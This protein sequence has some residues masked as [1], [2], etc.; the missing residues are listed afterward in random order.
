MDNF[1][2]GVRLFCDLFV[3]ETYAV[4]TVQNNRKYL[5][6]DDILSK[7][8]IKQMNRGD[9][10]FRR[11]LNLLCVVWKDTRDVT[12]LSTMHP[13][14]G[15]QTVQR[16]T[17][18]N[19]AHVVLQVPVPPAVLDYNRFMGG[20]DKGDQFC[21]YYTVKR[22]TRKWWKVIFFRSVDISIVNAWILHRQSPLHEP[23][24][25]LEFR[26][27]LAEELIGDF[28]SRKQPGRPSLEQRLVGKHFLEKGVSQKC[29]V[30]VRTYKSKK[31]R[32]PRDS[33]YWCV[34]CQPPV[35]LC[36]DPCNKIWHTK[37]K[38]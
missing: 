19:G 4:R 23:L 15:D 22:K 9:I 37:R 35:P 11:F 1:Y 34:D 24:S 13:A 7:N 12:L 21:T 5:P 31:M 6:R 17:K 2:S 33:S 30:C 20:V 36:I 16:H 38:F 26:L 27:Q 14:T 18:V 32:R 25:Q 8:S 28:T 29:A 3:R 10:A